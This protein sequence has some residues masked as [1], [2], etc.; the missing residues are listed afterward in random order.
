MEKKVH[1][2]NGKDH[3]KLA[4]YIEKIELQLETCPFCGADGEIDNTHTPHYWVQCTGCGAQVGDQCSERN[5]YS[6]RSH[7]NSIRNAA[8]SWN[9]RTDKIN[10]VA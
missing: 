4:P 10:Y 6:L 7:Q 3:K 8:D 2:G 9:R 1:I 5:Y